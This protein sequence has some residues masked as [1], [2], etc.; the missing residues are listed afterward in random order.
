MTD[1]PPLVSV[2]MP[3][4]Q[5][6]RWLSEALE[7]AFAQTFE[8]FELVAVDDGSTDGSLEILEEWSGRDSRLRIVRAPHGGLP[9]AREISLREARGRY[10]AFLDADDRWLPNRLE[11]QL[12]FADDETVVFSDAY[13]ATL[14]AEAWGTSSDLLPPPSIE[15]PT[16]GLFPVLLEQNFILVSTVLAP[17][18]QLVEAGSFRRSE[19]LGLGDTGGCCDLEMWLALARKSLKFHYV[20]EPLAIYCFHSE[21]MSEDHVQ[22][23]LDHLRVLDSFEDEV[24]SSVRALGRG[25]K[26]ARRRLEEAHRRHAWRLW[27][28]RDRRAARGHLVASLR[29]RPLAPRTWV[30][31]ALFYAPPLGRRFAERGTG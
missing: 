5:A 26:M 25:R 27:L 15:W 24:Q 21:Q 20:A 10:A 7:S 31:L 8:D 29:A 18:G 3:V 17:T 11:R 2:L 16:R 14:D 9:Y 13:V 23:E 12:P 6:E 19:R 28:A 4:Y 1:A 30:A 22:M